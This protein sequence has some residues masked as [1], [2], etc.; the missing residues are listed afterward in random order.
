M[1]VSLYGRT[2]GFHSGN[3]QAGAIGRL[4]RV[5]EYRRILALLVRRDL[6]VRYSESFLGYIWT[7]LEPLLMTLIYWFIFSKIFKRGDASEDPFVLF[8]LMGQL[9][10]GW[11]N[12]SVVGGSKALRAES[13]M[14]RSS[15]VPRELWILRVVMTGFVEYVFSLPVMAAFAL[16]YMKQPH[17]T[18][19]LMPVA[20]LLMFVLGTGLGLLLAPL[21]IL[22]RD[23][24]KLIPIVLRLLFYMS[25]VLYSIEAVVKQVPAIKYVYGL[26]PLVGPLSMARAGFYPD[27]LRWEYIWHSIALDVIIFALGMFTFIRL[28]RQ[29]LKEI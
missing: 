24:E 8:L 12:V 19:L 3:S 9:L 27:E 29:V 28:E 14:V 16:A 13:Q 7:I 2:S 6:K 11:F 23:S 20:W 10:W 25:P 1:T 21:N 15:N 26:N 22:V 5:W 4:R 17:V 18:M